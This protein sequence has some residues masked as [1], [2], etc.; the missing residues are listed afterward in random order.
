MPLKI[1]AVWQRVDPDPVPFAE[2][3]IQVQGVMASQKAAIAADLHF[4]DL[5]F[6]SV[7]VA[8]GNGRYPSPALWADPLIG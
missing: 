5:T 8:A 2:Q 4:R 3:G 6:R 7:P 1:Y